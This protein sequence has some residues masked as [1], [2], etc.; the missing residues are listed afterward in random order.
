MKI[1]LAKKISIM[2]GSPTTPLGHPLYSIQLGKEG[3]REAS[4]SLGKAVL[5]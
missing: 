2:H 3:R 1:L 5:A 4:F